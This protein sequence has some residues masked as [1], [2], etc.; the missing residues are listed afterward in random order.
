[1]GSLKYSSYWVIIIIGTL[2]TL[3]VFSKLIFGVP[4]DGDWFWALTGIGLAFES[5]IALRKQKKFDKKY[6]IVE[7]V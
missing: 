6:K 7:R 2:V 4:I 1:M 5:L 3:G